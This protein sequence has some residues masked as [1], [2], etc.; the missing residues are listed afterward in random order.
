MAG[1][2]C[3]RCTQDPKPHLSVA[4][5]LGDKRQELQE[6][7]QHVAHSGKAAVQRQEGGGGGVHGAGAGEPELFSAAWMV[8]KVVCRVGIKEHVV[9]KG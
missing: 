2:W 8:G 1:I 6:A 4:W 9:W 5:V 7:F 3:C